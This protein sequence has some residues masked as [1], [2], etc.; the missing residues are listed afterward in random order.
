[1]NANSFKTLALAGSIALSTLFVAC[2]KDNKMTPNQ[3]GG[4]MAT[5]S[6]ENVSRPKP[7]NQSGIFEGKEKVIKPREKATIKFS[8]GKGQRL[9]F[10]TMYGKSNDWFFASEQPGINLYDDRGQAITGDVSYAVKLYDNGTIDSK[11]EREKKPIA[12]VSDIKPSELMK[13]DLQYDEK[14]S[15]FTLTIT[16]LSSGIHETPFSPGVWAVSNFDGMKLLEE[17]PFFTPGKPS[18]PEITDIAQMGNPAKLMAKV[19][20]E[21]GLF[22]GISPLVVVVYKA[23]KNPVFEIGQK[24]K[25]IGLKNIAQMGDAKRLVEALKKMP[26]VKGVYMAGSSPITPGKSEMVK[27]DLPKDCKITYLTMYGFSNDWFY[28]NEKDLSATFRGDATGSTALFD[29]GTG[30]DQYPGAGNK[31]AH[32]KGTPEKE[33]KP[34]QKVDNKYP[35][36]QPKDILRITIR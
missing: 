36:P 26:E 18:N 6:I 24:D 2:H 5:V 12:E 14:K 16:N 29:S 27:V 30:F 13:L 35:I 28:A 1:M 7:F 15:E 34:I 4:T 23:D 20:N 8:A 25:G 3:K 22:T 9:M 10:A 31:Q 21:T 17:M 11:K 33:E 19:K 32:F